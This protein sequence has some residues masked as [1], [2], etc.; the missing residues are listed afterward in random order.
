MDPVDFQLL[1][2][3][4][5][6]CNLKDRKIEYCLTK[7]GEFETK[8]FLFIFCFVF[9]YLQHFETRDRSRKLEFPFTCICSGL[10]TLLHKHWKSTFITLTI[11]R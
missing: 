8:L 5:V 7:A 1:N 6:L 9:N 2:C 11:S 3:I 10:L 4:I